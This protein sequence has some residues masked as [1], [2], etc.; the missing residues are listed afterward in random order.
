MKIKHAN[1]ALMNTRHNKYEKNQTTHYTLITM[2][3]IQNVEN[4]KHWQECGLNRN[5]HSLLV[6]MQNDT[7]TLE[8][9]V[10]IF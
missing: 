9:S 7:A 8:G 5:I 3:K 2:A 6:G 10:A 4:S 1:L